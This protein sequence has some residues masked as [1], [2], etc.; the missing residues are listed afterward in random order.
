[1]IIHSKKLIVIAPPRCASRYLRATLKPDFELPGATAEV[2]LGD[3][4]YREVWGEYRKVGVVRD[5]VDR[6]LSSYGYLSGKVPDLEEIKHRGE[7]GGVIRNLTERFLAM[8]PTALSAAEGIE[9]LRRT[10]VYGPFFWDF[11]EAFTTF[12]GFGDGYWCEVD[13]LI[14]VATLP[15]P[16]SQCEFSQPLKASRHL[17]AVIKAHCLRT[18]PPGK[19]LELLSEEKVA[20]LLS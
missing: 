9:A 5:V 11:F 14:D 7:P 3:T 17:E 13:A 12:R 15:A 18:L 8:Y 19:K 16:A 10:P 2:M 20:K 6:F 1:M 4:R